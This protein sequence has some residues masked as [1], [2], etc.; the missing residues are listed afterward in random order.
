LDFALNT[1]T[2]AIRD[3]SGTLEDEEKIVFTERLIQEGILVRKA[4]ASS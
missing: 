2:F 3:I 4:R 1:P